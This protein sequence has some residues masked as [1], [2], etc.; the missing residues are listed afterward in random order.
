[1]I[2]TISVDELAAWIHRA[3]KEC[4]SK[5]ACYALAEYYD[6]ACNELWEATGEELRV[7]GHTIKI[8]WS[9]YNTLAEAPCKDGMTPD[10]CRE[11]LASKGDVFYY[12]PYGKSADAVFF[13]ESR[14]G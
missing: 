1:M 2:A 9:H 3:F 12:R 8:I 14:E 7:N 4:W 11:F 13:C 6:K 5:E 10:E